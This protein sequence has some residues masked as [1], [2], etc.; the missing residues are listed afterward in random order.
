MQKDLVFL[1]QK[2]RGAKSFFEDALIERKAVR[3]L[4]PHIR[5]IGHTRRH[6]AYRRYPAAYRADLKNAADGRSPRSAF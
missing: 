1:P 3:P 6:C 2:A 5:R 4:F